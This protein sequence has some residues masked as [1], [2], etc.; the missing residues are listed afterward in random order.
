MRA[1]C[2]GVILLALTSPAFAGWPASGTVYPGT[3]GPPSSCPDNDG[4][5]G[6]VAG[7]ANYPALLSG[8]AATINGAHGLGCLVAGVD[9][10]VGLVAAPS[11]SNPTLGGLPAGASYSAGAHTVTISSNNVTFSGWDMSQGG[12]LELVVSSGVTGTVISGNKF[13]VQSPNCL[14]P[15]RFNGLAGTTT[16]QYNQIDGGGAA[17]QTIAGGLTADV[18]IIGSSSG[19]VFNFQWNDQENVS[20]DGV[21]VPG[22]A[23]GTPLTFVY[24]Y[25][26]MHQVGWIGNPLDPNHPD[27]IQYDGGLIAAPIISHSTFYNSVFA[28]GTAG[29]Q[30]YHVE[31]QLTSTITN[32]VVSYNTIATPGTCNGGASYPTGCSENFSIACKNDTGGGEVDSNTGFAAYGNYIDWTGGIAAL[33]TEAGCTGT[34]WG[35]PKANYDMVLGTTLAAP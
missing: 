26:L 12:G 9:Y 34:A 35:A 8:Y 14:A 3:V 18:H 16:V 19:A 24:R 20:S 2:A 17:C 29:V 21:N 30:P 11:L 15:M 1:L 28:G 31:A 7:T 27:G 23:S 33:T 25:N 32:A 5:S 6:A 13:L 4:S 22:P 10:R